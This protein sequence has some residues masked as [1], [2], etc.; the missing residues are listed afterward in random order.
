MEE[1]EF[2]AVNAMIDQRTEEYLNDPLA[3]KRENERV[4]TSFKVLKIML[5]YYH[6]M[7]AAKITNER[8]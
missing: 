5:K 2:Q 3:N 1:R 6:K 4:L 8:R 7:G